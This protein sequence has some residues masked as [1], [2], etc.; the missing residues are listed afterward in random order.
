M[1]V[2]CGYA[3]VCVRVCVCMCMCT[4]ACVRVLAS[5]CIIKCNTTQNHRKPNQHHTC[6][7]N[8]MRMMCILLSI[9]PP[10]CMNKPHS[11]CRQASIIQ[12]N[13][14]ANSA[15][16]IHVRNRHH[17]SAAWF[18][19]PVTSASRDKTHE[20]TAPARARRPVDACECWC[21]QRLGHV[22]EHVA[23]VDLRGTSEERHACKACE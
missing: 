8:I 9:V 2:V 14:G 6:P 4:R 19:N 22:L 20:L 21:D 17:E 16:Y 7:P 23:G 1:C 12:I 3:Q 11:T 13:C 15:E 10:G 18:Q 5:I